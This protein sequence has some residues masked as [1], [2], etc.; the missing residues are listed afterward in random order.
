LTRRSLRLLAVGCLVAAGGLVALRSADGPAPAPGCQGLEPVAAVPDQGFT[1]QFVWYG[2]DNGD[3]PGYRGWTQGDGSWSVPITSGP[4]RGR[5]L[6]IHADTFL[7]G[8]RAPSAGL[9]APPPDP[10]VWPAAPSD[11]GAAILPAWPYFHHEPAGRSFIRNSAVL[12]DP[13]T[14][15]SDPGVIIETL[16]S[17]D[18]RGRPASWIA[19]E[20]ERLDPADPSWRRWEPMAAAVEHTES[21]DMLRVL[22]LEKAAGGEEGTVIDMGVASVPV[23]D[24][25]RE[26]TVVRFQP[27]PDPADAD[28]SRP[29]AERKVFYGYDIVQESA[30]TYVYGANANRGDMSAYV[31]R[32]PTGRLADPGAWTYFD[33]SDFVSG[34]SRARAILPRTAT[35][36]VAHGYTTARAGSTRLL[37]TMDPTTPYGAISTFT[38]YWSCGVAGPWTKTSWTLKAPAL[39]DPRVNP[40]VDANCNG[41]YMQAYNPHVHRQ[42]TDPDG[43]LL[44][45]YDMI[46]GQ[47]PTNWE[48]LGLNLDRYRPKFLRLT[49]GPALSARTKKLGLRAMKGT[50]ASSYSRGTLSGLPTVEELMIYLVSGILGISLALGATTA[51]VYSS[52]SSDAPRGELYNYGTH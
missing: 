2:N 8:V 36:G 22:M 33:G 45:S 17:T 39:C 20:F 18:A 34:E 40:T 32:V 47:G 42:F 52:S 51:V 13:G 26:P 46:P 44:L 14:A 1:D 19:G 3:R 38:A 50:G 23:N 12:A 30:W 29:P 6:W 31:A 16:S 9:V 37:F 49:L 25:R 24:L 7:G 15:P 28:S 43:R 35:T 21:G 11:P 48:R 4:D 41:G 27:P 10:A 5:T